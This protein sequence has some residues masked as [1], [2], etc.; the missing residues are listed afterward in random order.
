MTTAPTDQKT[1]MLNQQAVT[2]IQETKDVLTALTNT[3]KNPH[4][5]PNHHQA[6]VL[7]LISQIRDVS[8]ASAVAIAHT[9]REEPHPLPITTTAASLGLSVNTTKRRLADDR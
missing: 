8:G 2:Y 6:E 4:R 9:A 3:L 1:T 7:K 5:N